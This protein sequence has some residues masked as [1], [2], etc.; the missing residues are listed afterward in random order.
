MGGCVELEPWEH[1][2]AHGYSSVTAVVSE[3][4]LL[5]HGF[6]VEA[7]VVLPVKLLGLVHRHAAI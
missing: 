1:V 6:A 5:G 7:L 4:H 3:E 2:V